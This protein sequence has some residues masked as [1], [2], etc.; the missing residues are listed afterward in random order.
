MSLQDKVLLSVAF[1]YP[2]KKEP[3]QYQ[4][5]M[6]FPVYT[7]NIILE[8]LKKRFVLKVYDED[9]LT[10]YLKIIEKVQP[11]IIHIHGTENSYLCIIGKT[12]VP[13][14]VSIQGSL[15]VY[16]HKFFSGFHGKF[17]KNKSESL[18]LKSLLFGKLN[19]RYGYNTMKKMAAIEQRNL[20]RAENIIGRT[21]WDRR[22]TRILAP[23]SI[24]Y[25]GNEI[26]REAFYEA[27]WDKRIEANKIIIF[28]TN[29]NNYY[30]GFETLCHALTL[31]NNTGIDVE[32]RV[33]GITR[34]SLINIITRK[35]LRKD[36]P[37]KGLVLLGSLAENEL[38]SKMKG[39]DIYVMPSHIENSP[40]NLCEAMILGMPCIASFAGGTG[41]ILKDGEEGILVQDGDPW[42][43]AGAILELAQNQDC[44]VRFGIKA[45]E[46]ALLRHNKERIINDLLNIYFRI[47]QNRLNDTLAPD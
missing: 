41:S 32:W 47:K 13:V 25:I 18:S 36:Y 43:L 11:D 27:M 23:D 21:D 33:A 28:T 35:A 37:K 45:R 20:R 7:G 42:V 39:A 17:L 26:L 40:N 4:N 19:F 30:K 31:L 8:G 46:R 9:Y 44:A 14:A 29:G 5:S 2:Y 24:Y 10:E 34:E 3:F 38:I 6:Y 12:K 1:H 16:Y 22:I 15:T